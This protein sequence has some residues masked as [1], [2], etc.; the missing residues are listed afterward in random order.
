M[1]RN[2]KTAPTGNRR[3]RGKQTQNRANRPARS[4]SIE[5]PLP[6]AYAQSVGPQAQGTMGSR[7]AQGVDTQP[8][9]ILR[10]TASTTDKYIT[11]PVISDL[12]FDPAKNVGYGGRARYLAGLAALHSQHQWR[13]LSFR[14]TPS[15]AVVTPG[16]VV[17]KFFPNY[18]EGLPSQME[19][20]MDISALT[21]SP[22]EAHTYRVP[23]RINGLKN[24]CSVAQFMAMSDDDKSD[25]SIGRLVVGCTAQTTAL[26]LG[27]LQILPNVQFSGP[28][29]A[30]VASEPST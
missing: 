17:L 11:V 22:Y 2:G 14:W 30:S 12:L 19:D 29:I 16:V 5:R 1:N 27:Y 21:I 20:L 28:M 23:G 13:S 18:K 10:V 8:E 3:G 9:I 24:N 6:L 7:S 15:C 26:T 4:R 25:Y